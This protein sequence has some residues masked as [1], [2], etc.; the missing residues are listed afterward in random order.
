MN[1]ERTDMNRIQTIEAMIETIGFD[2]L[3]ALVAEGLRRRLNVREIARHLNIPLD[4][5]KFFALGHEDEF[6]LHPGERIRALVPSAFGWQGFGTVIKHSGD[7]VRFSIDGYK[8]G[9]SDHNYFCRD[10]VELTTMPELLPEG[11]TFDENDYIAIPCELS[12]SGMQIQF[13]CPHCK[14]T[15]RHNAEL[16]GAGYRTPH[17]Q[18]RDSPLWARSNYYIY[19]K[20]KH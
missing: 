1:I 12:P 9:T 19:P 15:H 20:S 16:G 18:K 11:A 7:L 14:T 8:P 5:A 17:C 13:Y 2:G 10:Q 4:K 3:E 6:P